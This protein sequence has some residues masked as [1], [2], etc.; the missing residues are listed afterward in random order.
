MMINKKEHY[1]V[2][3]FVNL[4][5]IVNSLKSENSTIFTENITL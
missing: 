5:F 2:S 4:L 3:F 1:L